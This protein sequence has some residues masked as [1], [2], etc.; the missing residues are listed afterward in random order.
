MHKYKK[1]NSKN[2]AKSNRKS[3]I[4]HAENQQ[5]P[6]E[7]EMKQRSETEKMLFEGDPSKVIQFDDE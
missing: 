1:K 4:D 2:K 7:I 6:R 5:K 3:D